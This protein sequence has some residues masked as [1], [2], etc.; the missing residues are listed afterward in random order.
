MTTSVVSPAVLIVGAGIAG[1]GVAA[2]FDRRGVRVAGARW[3]IEETFQ[4]AKLLPPAVRDAALRE[5]G[6]NM[7][8]DRYRPLAT[9]TSTAGRRIPM[10]PGALRRHCLVERP[11]TLPR[12]ARQPS[13]TTPSSARAASRPRRS[14]QAA[15]R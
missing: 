14:P 12:A 9:R 4:T 10:A 6:D 5:R 3:A 15:R 11:P 2:A 13:T 1:L 8:R 7:L